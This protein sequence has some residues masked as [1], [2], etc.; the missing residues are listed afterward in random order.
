M[1]GSGFSKQ[2][3]GIQRDYE[4]GNLEKRREA[5]SKLHVACLNEKRPHDALPLLER[6]LRDPDPD[7]GESAAHGMGACR[8]HAFPSLLRL[9]DDPD[10]LV[11]ERVCH[12][13][14]EMEVDRQ[15]AR[16]P[17]LAALADAAPGVRGRAAFALGRM[18]DTATTTIDAIAALAKDPHDETRRWAL[19]GLAMIGQEPAARRA[20]AAHAGMILAAL[21]DPDENAR[22]NAATALDDLQLSAA[23]LLPR[24]IDRLAMETSDSVRVQLDGALVGLNSREDLAPHVPSLI[25]RATEPGPLRDAVISIC[26]RLGPLGAVVVPLIREEIAR[27][28]GATVNNIMALH[29]MTGRVDECV[30][31]LKRLLDDDWPEGFRPVRELWSLTGDAAIVNPYLASALA[32]SPDEPAGLITEIGPAAAAVLPALVRSIEENFDEEDWDVMWALTDALSALESPDPVAVTAL[33][34]CL[35]HPSGIVKGSALNGLQSAGPAA[36][37]AL[38]ALRQVLGAGDAEWKE[39]VRDVIGAIE[40]LAN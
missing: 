3:A 8:K 18:R 19:N 34:R 25:S 7:V 10:A 15:A 23:Q 39:A 35:S 11:R 6:M 40:S 17:L 12:A 38:P 21:D 9:I 14:G 30:A 5:A 4:S 16:Q 24:I 32:Q 29:A 37:P 26:S 33:I 36:R 20:L 2:V 13:F 1:F 22:W 27:P 28:G 31:A